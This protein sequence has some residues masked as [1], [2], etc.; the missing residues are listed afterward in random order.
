MLTHFFFLP[1]AVAFFS[2][3]MKCP[4]LIKAKQYIMDFGESWNAVIPSTKHLSSLWFNLCYLFSLIKWL[5]GWNRHN[6]FFLINT[7]PCT[8]I[9]SIW[10]LHRLG[11][12][13]KEKMSS[14]K[15]KCQM[16]SV[17][18]KIVEAGRFNRSSRGFGVREAWKSASAGLL[19]CLKW[20][21]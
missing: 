8:L 20:V 21:P 12:T 2:Y 11:G 17:S 14:H 9:S 15:G 3:F 18:W 10:K 16:H 13:I 5:T 1:L 4:L 7:L 6:S 19:M